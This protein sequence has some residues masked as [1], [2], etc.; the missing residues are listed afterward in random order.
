MERYSI[1][2]RAKILFELL[3]HSVKTSTIEQILRANDSLIFQEVINQ[4]NEVAIPYTGKFTFRDFIGREI[5]SFNVE[6]V[7]QKDFVKS[8]FEFGKYVKRLNINRDCFHRIEI[9]QSSLKPC[10]IFN[11]KAAAI[12][13]GQKELLNCLT[14]VYQHDFKLSGK[15]ELFN[16]EEL[17]Q[18]T[19]AMEQLLQS[20]PTIHKQIEPFIESIL[21]FKE[22]V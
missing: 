14:T 10:I 6:V 5:N 4:S 8:K 19:N 9:D 2:E 12:I 15:V 11:S 21:A 20:N 1:S 17:S 13:S 7:R 3:G 18:F 22:W 16:E